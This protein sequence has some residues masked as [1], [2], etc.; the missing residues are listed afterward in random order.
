MQ[1]RPGNEIHLYHSVK[2]GDCCPA[3][4]GPGDGIWHHLSTDGGKTW[5]NAQPVLSTKLQPGTSPA[6]SIAGKYMP[7]M[8]G[9]KGGMVIITD[10]GPGFGLH[11]YMSKSPG[12]MVNFVAAKQPLITEH[13]SATGM[14]PGQWAASQI[15]FVPDADGAITGVSFSLYTDAKV[16][17]Q[18]HRMMELGYTHTIYNFT[19]PPH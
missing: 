7:G 10:G 16:Y 6:E 3:P 14:R 15:G 12:D 2:G 11:A 5:Q 9:G 8:L 17:S 13:P 19:S 4:T 1:S 18:R